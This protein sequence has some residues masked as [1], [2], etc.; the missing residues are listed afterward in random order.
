MN[1]L[2]TRTGT[3]EAS[4]NNRI[5]EMEERISDIEIMIKEMDTLTE[6]NAK[7]TNTQA[8][9]TQ[10]LWDIMKRPSLQSKAQKISSISNKRKIP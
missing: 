10:Q 8:Q 6:E 1:N 3:S 4:L 2:G 5:Q 7:S 9:N